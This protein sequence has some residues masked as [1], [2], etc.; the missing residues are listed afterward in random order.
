MHDPRNLPCMGAH[1]MNVSTDAICRFIRDEDGGYTLWSLVWFILFC[2]IGGL[3]VDAT[4]AYRHQ[5]LLQSTA[6]ASALAGVTM[7]PDTE[8]AVAEALHY[9]TATLSDASHGEVLKG[10][11][12]VVGTWD[13]A[14]H[15][16]SAGGASPNAVRVVTRRSNLNDNP[17]SMSMLRI[18]SIF[19]LNPEW[20]INVDAIAIR[21]L[22]KCLNDG[23]VAMN[24]VDINSNNNLSN[25]ICL[26]GQTAGV[27]MQNHN[28]FA[29]GVQISMPNLGLLPDRENLLGMNP[30]LAEALAEG[31]LYPRDIDF[32]DY[33]IAGLRNLDPNYVPDYM[34]RTGTN[35]EIIPP[36]K[37]TGSD[38]PATLAEYTVYDISCDGQLKLPSVQ[39]VKMVIVAD[40]RIQSSAGTD[41]QDVVVATSY[42]GNNAAIDLAAQTA[43]G[44]PDNCAPGGGVELYTPGDVNIAAQGNWHGLRVVAG[45]DV[46]LTALN[47]GIHGMSVQAGHD[48]RFTSN[49]DF[50]LCSG[51]VPGTFAWSYRLVD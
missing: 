26:H 47:V 14:T 48:I 4:N 16:F 30:G 24:R 31:D 38:L 15:R 2:L 35:G 42:A 19:G 36:A 17:V 34:Y 41:L 23:F 45:R 51:S 9:S 12:V 28:T 3:A 27:D 29:P 39:M 7:L 13:A 20:N 40:C 46:S 37:V 6:D 18:A 49:N 43:L 50:A 10:S 25:F 1:E 8:A 5:A 22:P 33:R 44:R 32:V 21:Y 11:D